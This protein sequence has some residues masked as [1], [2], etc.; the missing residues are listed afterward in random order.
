[1]TPADQ[2]L[3][4]RAEALFGDAPRPEHHTDH[5]H[6]CECAE[7]DEALQAAAPATVSFAVLGNPAWDPMCFVTHEAFR[8]WFPALVRLALV[9]DPQEWYVSQLLFHLSPNPQDRRV[10]FSAEQRAFVR[11]LLDHLADTRRPRLEEYREWELLEAARA[12]W[13]AAP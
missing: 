13:Q 5:R 6:C 12:H 10:A 9:E 4:A 8:Y 7:H 2:E 11:D 1:M 3:L